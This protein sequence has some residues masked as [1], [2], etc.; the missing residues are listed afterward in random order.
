MLKKCPICGNEL[1]VTS[2]KCKSC[3]TVISGKF[4]FEDSLDFDIEPEIFD[5]IKIF[6]YSE[7]NIKQVEKILGWSY[8]KVK[9]YLK[10]AKKALGFE[11]DNNLDSDEKKEILDKI[12]KG[13]LSV[14]DAISLLKE[15]G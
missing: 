7:G 10:K 14:K 8:P 6:I 3:D 13:E 9:N 5:F 4:P 11:E 15:R 1:I 12:E 2:L